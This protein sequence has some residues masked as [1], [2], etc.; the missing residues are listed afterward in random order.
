M[1]KG[2][3]LMAIIGLVG[4]AASAALI[5]NEPMTKNEKYLKEARTKINEFKEELEPE[6]LNEASMALENINLTEE[7]DLQIRTRL[8]RDCLYEWLTLDQIL[9]QHLDP[10]FNPSDVPQKNIQPPSSN[11]TVL[12]PGVDPAKISDPQARANYEKAIADNRAKAESYRLQT[13][14][15]RL[16]ESIPPKAEE[17]IRNSYTS[18]TSAE[19]DQEELKKAINEII[20]KPERKAELSKHL[21]TAQP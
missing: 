15:R 7:Y 21:K 14:L 11:G 5:R 6:R 17:F 3:I 4:L 10:K 12:S 19:V 18:A 2:L 13:Q 8:R 20:Q 1:M 9:D 16:N